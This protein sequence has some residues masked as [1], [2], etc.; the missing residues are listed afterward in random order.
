MNLKKCLVSS[1]LLFFIFQEPVLSS[2]GI[3]KMLKNERLTKQEMGLIKKDIKINA[4]SSIRSL[5]KVVKSDE[6]PDRSRWLSLVLIGK[7]MGKRSVPL[8]KKYLKHDHWMIRSAAVKSLTSLKERKLGDEYKN[9]LK[10]KSF[11]IRQQVLE[12]ISSLR[13]KH[14][15]KDVLRMLG[16]R[17]NYISTKEGVV[18]S[19]VVKKAVKVLAILDYKDSLPLL[20]KLVKSPLSIGLKKDLT[21]AIASLSKK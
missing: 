17:T 7:T 15:E 11:V 20:R 21:Q 4:K 16:D 13:I 9:L 8:M 12:T 10:D 2:V 6:Y 19:E 14:L 5:L 18:P 1:S 3:E